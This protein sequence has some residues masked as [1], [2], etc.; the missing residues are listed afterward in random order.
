MVD[1]RK[2]EKIF[3]FDWTWFKTFYLIVIIT[4]ISL[5]VVYLIHDS[6]SLN[7]NIKNKT[8]PDSIIDFTTS[9][10]SDIDFTTSPNS[11]IDF[12]TSPNSSIDFTTLPNSNVDFTTLPNS[13]VDF[14]TSSEYNLT[15]QLFNPNIEN[16]KFTGK[17]KIPLS[18]KGINIK[19]K[20]PVTIDI[21]DSN[22]LPKGILINTE[23]SFDKESL[24]TSFRFM[25]N[26][27]QEKGVKKVKVQVTDSLNPKNSM[28][29]EILFDISKN[30]EYDIF[31]GFSLVV[32][33]INIMYFVYICYRG[34]NCEILNFEKDIIYIDVPPVLWNKTKKLR[35]SEKNDQ[36][37]I[38]RW[39]QVLCVSY[40][41]IPICIFIFNVIILIFSSIQIDK[42]KGKDSFS[43]FMVT[44]FIIYICLFGA[45]YYETN[46]FTDICEIMINKKKGPN[47]Y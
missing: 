28:M 37:F 23:G 4:L 18:N 35:I 15:D 45:K 25:K 43:L 40:R 9:P 24:T 5:I 38:D 41:V 17:V 11:S 36:K 10:E 3:P 46:V 13:N 44:N 21:V 33:F 47:A 29:D 2:Q 19:Y 16:L 22:S 32:I 12:T 26:I 1:K 14:T 6:S 30:I 7:N 31:F 42:T 27:P 39:E 20:N 8:S 34:I